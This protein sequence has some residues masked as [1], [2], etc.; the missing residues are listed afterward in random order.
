M[1]NLKEKGGEK[2]EGLI[3]SDTPLWKPALVFFHWNFLHPGPLPK[4]DRIRSDLNQLILA[5][6]L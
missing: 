3:G 2:K 5:Y 6:E 4:P 1:C